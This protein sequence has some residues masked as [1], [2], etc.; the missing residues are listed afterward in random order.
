MPWRQEI[1]LDLW[2]SFSEF[3]QFYYDMKERFFLWIRIICK[4][5]WLQQVQEKKKDKVIADHKEKAT[6]RPNTNCIV[7]NRKRRKHRQ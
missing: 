4:L 5:R 2:K 6:E 1:S 3:I 7:R